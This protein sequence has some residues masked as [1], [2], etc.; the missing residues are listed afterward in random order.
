MQR[1]LARA[2]VACFIA[3]LSLSAGL[4]QAQSKSKLSA[5]EPVEPGSL[6]GSMGSSL[7]SAPSLIVGRNVVL[8]LQ[9]QIGRA[10]V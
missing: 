4:A 1:Q 8:T 9:S 2:T 5:V 6:S 10:H 7:G 3:L